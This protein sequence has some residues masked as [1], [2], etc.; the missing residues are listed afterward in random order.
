MAQ[1]T[2]ITDIAVLDPT[3]FGSLIELPNILKQNQLSASNAKA[4]TDNMLDKIKAVDLTKIDLTIL[5]D[6]LT[7]AGALRGKLVTTIE[8]MEGKRKPKTSFLDKVRSMFTA[9][10]KI[11]AGC[12]EDIK[13]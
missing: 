7:A 2:S 13:V 12:V 9:E 5:E 3:E 4:A 6:H 8:K 11:V 1:T 10:E